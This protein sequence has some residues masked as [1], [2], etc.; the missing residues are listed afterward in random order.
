MKPTASP[1][2]VYLD[3]L[4][5]L[6][7]LLMVQDHA[8]DWWLR[9]EFHSTPWGRTTEYLGTFAAPLFLLLMGASLAL[10]MEKRRGGNLP[11][12]QLALVLLRRGAFLI[13]QGYVVAWLVFYNGHN[14]DEM[15]SVDVLHCLGLGLVVM[16]PLA[17][18][19]SW[20]LTALATI[21]T[22]LAG[23]WAGSWDL[24]PWP[25]TWVTGSTGIAY[26]PLLPFVTYALAGLGLGQAYVLVSA[27]SHG[28]RRFTLA[29][30]ALGTGLVPLVPFVP[31]DIG[32]RF[33]RPQFLLFSLAVLFYLMAA[34]VVLA[35]WPGSLHPLT[36]I[37]KAAMMVYVAHHLLGF[38]LFYHLRWVTGHSWNG[39]YG[40]FDPATAGFLLLA[41]L[42]VLYV[43]GRLWLVW[44][45]RIGPAALVRRWAPRL[46]TY[47]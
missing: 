37:G 17:L 35:R 20:P 47:W 31:P 33:P 22:A 46:S 5:G 13:L 3:A 39:Q 43:F 30:V 9:S 14:L 4:R 24:P 25:A 2:L 7:I 1:R 11:G 32:F 27:R 44:R 42:V 45:P 28:D 18:A 8:F 29:L 19:R 36:V 21:A 41:L 10:S 23:V 12:W 38:R 16:I 6:A 34:F 15:W 26:F 40:V